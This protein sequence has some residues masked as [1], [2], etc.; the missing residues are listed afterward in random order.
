M[1][2]HACELPHHHF[3]PL[4][5]C[6]AAGPT[7]IDFFSPRA[8]LDKGKNELRDLLTLLFTDFQPSLS[9]DF[10]WVSAYRK[11]GK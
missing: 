3:W 11:Y 1:P 5:S 10:E 2:R 7:L 8:S 6:S 4:A 9:G